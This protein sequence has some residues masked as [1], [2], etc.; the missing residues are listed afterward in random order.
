VSNPAGITPISSCNVTR[1]GS[2]GVPDVQMV[3]NE[4]LGNLQPVHFLSGGSTV[5]VTD[6]QIVVD[7]VMGMGCAPV[8]L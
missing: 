2:T 8:V 6:V 5:G 4:V 7:A 1:S 3:L